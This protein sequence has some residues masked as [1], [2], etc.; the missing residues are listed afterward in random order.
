MTTHPRIIRIKEDLIAHLASPVD[1]APELMPAQIVVAESFVTIS[2]PAV[3]GGVLAMS[4]E[5]LR[6]I[7]TSVAAGTFVGVVVFV[8]YETRHLDRG[9]DESG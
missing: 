1:L 3:E 8:G 7:E 9:S 2:A 5:G 4:I 6:R